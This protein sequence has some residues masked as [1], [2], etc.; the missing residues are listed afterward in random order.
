M[1][2]VKA[3]AQCMSTA[4]EDI[5][6]AEDLRQQVDEELQEANYEPNGTP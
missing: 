4:N 3:V 2:G 5:A 1:P 6:T